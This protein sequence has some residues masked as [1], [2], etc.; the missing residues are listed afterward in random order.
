MVSATKGTDPK[1]GGRGIEGQ[2]NLRLFSLLVFCPLL[3]RHHPLIAAAPRCEISGLKRAELSLRLDRF[4][5][6]Y[7]DPEY[8]IWKGGRSKAKRHVPSP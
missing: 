8:D 5:A 7:A 2:G 6:Q 3:L 1:A 4:F